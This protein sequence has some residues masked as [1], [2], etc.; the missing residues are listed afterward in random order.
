MIYYDRYIEEDRKE[1]SEFRK[2][3]DEGK[4]KKIKSLEAQIVPWWTIPAWCALF[5]GI[6]ALTV[7]VIQCAS[8]VPPR[9]M[10]PYEYNCCARMADGPYYYPRYK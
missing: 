10:H 3:R 6:G 8:D 4:D 9:L 1:L 2:A 7:F 5:A